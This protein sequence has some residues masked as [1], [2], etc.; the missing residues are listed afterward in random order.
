MRDNIN[1]N[2][3]MAIIT[4][5]ELKEILSENFV[6]KQELEAEKNSKIGFDPET[7]VYGIRGIAKLFN[8]S[9]ATAQR[10][11]NT[12]LAQAVIQNGKKIIVDKQ[13]A[14]E[15]FNKHGKNSKY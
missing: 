10:Y 7:H 6:T 11:K 15:L 12:F 13:L 3:P 9:H 14:I 4:V 1:D 5:G 2:T 8:V